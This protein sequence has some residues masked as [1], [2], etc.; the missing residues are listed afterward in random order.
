MILSR[1]FV[2]MM[3]LMLMICKIM[4]MKLV[5]L[6]LMMFIVM[7][8][9]M[10]LLIMLFFMIIIVMMM[11]LMLLLTFG[12]ALIQT[13]LPIVLLML[14]CGSYCGSGITLTMIAV[15]HTTCGIRVWRRRVFRHDGWVTKVSFNNA[16][17]ISTMLVMIILKIGCTTTTTSG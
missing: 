7:M 13:L 14:N 17:T 2:V 6:L 8:I 11:M 10:M 12:P 4:M 5:L 9:C 16:T 1:G 3:M 15:H